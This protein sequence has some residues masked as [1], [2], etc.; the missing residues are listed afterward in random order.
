MEPEP[1]K[2]LM[3]WER[4][5]APNVCIQ[6]FTEVTAGHQYQ[7]PLTQVLKYQ[8]DKN[9]G[10]VQTEYNRKFW[11]LIIWR[12]REQALPTGKSITFS[13]KLLC[14]LSKTHP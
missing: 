5:K 12:E 8:A 3:N 7:W 6:N 10:S 4:Q 14:Q 2:N 11:H 9:A 1:R 13:L